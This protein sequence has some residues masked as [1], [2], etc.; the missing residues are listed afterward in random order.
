ME[1]SLMV[2]HFLLQHQLLQL[3]KTTTTIQPQ[4]LLMLHLQQLLCEPK[5]PMLVL[6]VYESELLT[7][8]ILRHGLGYY[9]LLEELP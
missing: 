3:R 5:Q 8:N 9:R 4:Q 1:G 2:E 6:R 7:L